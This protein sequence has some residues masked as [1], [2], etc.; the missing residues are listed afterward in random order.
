[1]AEI[2][3]KR[4]KPSDDAHLWNALDYVS[5]DRA[6]M[7][8]GNG[9]DYSNP[10]EAYRQMNYVKKYFGK[11][12]NCALVHVMVSYNQKV[13]NAETACKFTEQVAGFFADNYQTMYCAHEKDN[14]CSTYHAHIIVNPVNVNDGKIM[15]TNHEN[16]QPF[17]KEVSRIT[18]T[19]YQVEFNKDA[20]K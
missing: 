17:C 7:I 20:S 5:D 11:A 4:G 19:N 8:G 18:G 14:E 2:I 9:V 6:L 1:M 10:D 12:K 16:M 15:Q 13:D 3:L